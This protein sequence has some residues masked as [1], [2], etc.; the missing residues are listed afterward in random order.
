MD[1]LNIKGK[2]GRK[3]T[4]LNNYET[5]KDYKDEF[6]KKY[7]EKIKDSEEFKQKLK[8]INKKNYEKQKLKKYYEKFGTYKGFPFKYL[9]KIYD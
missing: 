9:Q 8:E 2:R 7:Y 1:E 6:N 3:S 5:Y 4:I